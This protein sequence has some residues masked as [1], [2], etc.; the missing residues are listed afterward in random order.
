MKH[1]TEDTEDTEDAVSNV[2]D[3]VVAEDLDDTEDRIEFLL[4][5]F[6]Q[7]PLKAENVLGTYDQ[8]YRCSGVSSLRKFLTG[9]ATRPDFPPDMQLRAVESLLSFQEHPETIDDDDSDSF[10]QIKA[11]ANAGV[12]QRNA[13]RVAGA[14]QV[15]I[16]LIERTNCSWGDG[17]MPT[18]LKYKAIVMLARYG[19]KA[20]D[21]K[22]ERF[23]N[24]L[25][26]TNRLEAEF[27]YKLVRRLEHEKYVS[28]DIYGNMLLSFLGHTPNPTTLRILSAQNLLAGDFD[29]TISKDVILIQVL[30]FA[31]DEELDTFVRADAADTLI[32]FGN[33]DDAAEG[34]RILD[35]LGTRHGG[36]GI[37]NNHQNVH[38]ES[39]ESSI[40]GGIEKLKVIADGPLESFEECRRKVTCIW[41]NL[42]DDKERDKNVKIADTA[43]DRINY[44]SRL[45]RGLD[46]KTLFQMVCTVIA[47]EENPETKSELYK[48]CAEEIL[49]MAN[50]CSSGMASRM[51]NV[52]SG[53]GSFQLAISFKEQIQ[54][55]FV[56]R[57]N[58]LVKLIGQKAESGNHPFF[59]ACNTDIVHLW[60]MKDTPFDVPTDARSRSAQFADDIGNRDDT[61]AIP[62][63]LPALPVDRT[64]HVPSHQESRKTRVAKWLELF[65]DEERRREERAARED[66]VGNLLTEFDASCPSR[67]RFSLF[68]TYAFSSLRSQMEEEFRQFVT[69]DEFE[70]YM[71]DALAFYEG[72]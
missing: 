37:Y 14:V 6:R 57:L 29:K 68:M 64:T 23:M 16:G 21:E 66:F 32:G 70:L 17:C 8:A 67:L 45:F 10:K 33:E 59:D 2:D 38:A 55:N 18:L 56:G 25:I 1:D 27:R 41:D 31:C 35:E 4:E 7:S 5:Y 61:L 72:C 58:A 63:A 65:D 15:L 3:L 28:T 22:V 44:D 11:D 52:L 9:V 39:I 36:L 30:I 71:R 43:F 46:L 47:N 20:M 49:D 50:T 69:P 42:L 26:T 13:G 54:S 19:R 34:R 60:M 48:R 62:R 53:F 12:S 51:I 40:D 24:D